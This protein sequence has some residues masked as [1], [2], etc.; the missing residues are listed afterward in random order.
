MD[1]SEPNLHSGVPVDH[2]SGTTVHAPEPSSTKREA[3]AK[4]DLVKIK[5][6]LQVN[7][8]S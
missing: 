1:A 6:E 5:G 4:R 8:V 3:A 7:Q 2:G